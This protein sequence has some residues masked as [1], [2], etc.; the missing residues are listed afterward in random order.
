M[1]RKYSPAR[2]IG[3]GVVIDP[4]PERHKRRDV[5]VIEQ[6]KLREK[7]DPAE[8]LLKS[9][10]RAG[11]DGIPRK[12]ADPDLLAAVVESGEVWEC[13]D[14]VIDRRALDSLAESV[15]DLAGAYQVRNPLQW[16]IDKEELRQRTGF[17]HAAPVFNKI[18]EK[19]GEIRPV[20]VK[21]NRVRSGAAEMEL[22]DSILG[23]VAGLL[24]RI[25]SA[26]VA[27]PLRAELEREWRG[28]QRFADVVQYLKEGGGVVEVGEGLIHRDAVGEC[29][30]VMRRLFEE[31][32]AI[33]VA[34]IK[35]AL[36]LTRKHTIPLLEMFDANRVTVRSGNNRVKGPGFTG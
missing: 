30:D 13:D 9:I 34:D 22:P 27:F 21:G 23:E 5:S 18:L 6:L 36:G 8:V 2:V 19:L 24:E 12:N 7:G 10:E 3:G 29:V 32:E 26:G 31:K 14:L 1:L 17:P 33:S 20:F 25:K 11:L 28:K 4:A 15:E 35:G 16:G